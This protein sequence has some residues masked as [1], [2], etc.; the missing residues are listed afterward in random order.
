MPRGESSPLC[1]ANVESI[2]FLRRFITISGRAHNPEPAASFNL[3]MPASCWSMARCVSFWKSPSIRESDRAPG[4]PSWTRSSSPAR[5]CIHSGGSM[6]EPIRLPM[7]SA[8]SRLSEAKLVSTS[9][10][11]SPRVPG[12]DRDTRAAM[13]FWASAPRM[14]SPT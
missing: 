2:G 14:R 10:C 1:S 9:A 7:K 8:I 6:P 4:R 11:V 13:R 5:R 3:V 12:Q